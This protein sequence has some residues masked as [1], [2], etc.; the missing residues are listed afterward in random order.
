MQTNDVIKQ[1]AKGIADQCIGSRVRML[2]RIVTRTYDEML[3][4]LGIKFSQL[5]IL[6]VVAKRGSV[7][8][9]EVGRI[10]SIEKST[11]S[12]NVRLMEASG[13]IETLPGGGGNTHLLRLTSQ[14]RQLYKRAAPAWRVA[15]KKLTNLLGDQTVAAI[16]LAVERVRQLESTK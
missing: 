7:Q 12:R 1:T 14:G 9:A 15:Q 10:L 3:R 13:W 8:P 2:N 5:N 16:Q 11:L 6:T 4:S